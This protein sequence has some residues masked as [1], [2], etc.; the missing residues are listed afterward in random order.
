MK[1]MIINVNTDVVEFKDFILPESESNGELE[2]LKQEALML[3]QKSDVT[4][5]R[6]CENNLEIPLEWKEYRESLRHFINN[7]TIRD[8][9]LPNPPT[10]TT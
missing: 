1:E 6:Y 8:K 7:A 5:L 10:Y 3:L 2:A 9:T 4:L